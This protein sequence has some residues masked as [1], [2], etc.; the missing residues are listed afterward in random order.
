MRS[1]CWSLIVGGFGVGCAPTGADLASP[2]ESLSSSPD[3]DVAD[4]TG[5]VGGGDDC[6][7]ASVDVVSIGDVPESVPFE[8]ILGQS[9]QHL[10]NGLWSTGG[11]EDS[12]SA[13][14]TFD[15][16][17][18][19]RSTSLHVDHEQPPCSVR[20]EALYTIELASTEKGWSTSWEGG[21]D[22][23]ASLSFGANR[24]AE[25]WTDDLPTPANVALPVRGVR[26][27]VSWGT[28]VTG[29]VDVV[30]WDDA[31]VEALTFGD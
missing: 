20:W 19:R 21:R 31:T 29:S 6:E 22:L 30:G 15:E 16:S 7:A 10:L 2:S 1:L 18:L 26:V 9:G 8:S 4:V 23:D 3:D 24:P 28:N 12:I 17:H 27:N 13:T 14:L 11:V 25:E 5:P